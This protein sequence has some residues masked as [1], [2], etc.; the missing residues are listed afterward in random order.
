[1]RLSLLNNKTPLKDHLGFITENKPLYHYLLAFVVGIISSFATIGFI[2]LYQLI[3]HFIY[4]SETSN[5]AEIAQFTSIGYF[6]II[7]CLGG[8]LIGL[9]IYYFIPYHG[10]GHG[11]PHLLYCYRHFKPVEVSEGLSA[12]VANSLSLGLGASV[13][14]E[15]PG[16]FLSSSITTWLCRLLKVHAHTL[17]VMIAAAVGTSLATSLHSSFVGFFFIMEVISYSLTAIDLLPITLAI[18]TGVFIRD[19]FP[20]I[21]P[22]FSLNIRIFDSGINLLPFILL[23]IL[24]GLFAFLLIKTLSFTIKASSNSRLPKWSWPLLG[25]LGL[26]LIAIRFPDALGLGFSDMGL[27]LETSLPI[28]PLLFLAIAKFLAIIF[29]LGFGFSGGIFTP[30]VF[31]GMCLGSLYV[32][33]LS[34]IF[35]HASL[36]PGMYALMG[37]AA[38]TSVVI[39][40]PI[41]MTFFAFEL[42]GNLQICVNTFIVVFFAQLVMKA[43]GFKSFFQNQ[44]T[45]LY[46]R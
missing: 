3:T 31:W 34:A 28:Y 38:F 30:S 14:R 46:N 24:C 42:T 43:F 33:I 35:P 40:A 1:M 4:H 15:M 2:K 5:F 44:Y 32:A 11:F 29:S 19:F 7:F 10:H 37:A 41:T 26:S 25:G 18:F 20:E 27:M 23:G 22:P 13:G 8:L 36:S 17:R 16:I 9:F 45:Y 6:F 12:T 39:G 21:L